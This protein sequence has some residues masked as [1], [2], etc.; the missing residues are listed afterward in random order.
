M[1]STHL[2]QC[3]YLSSLTYSLYFNT[4]LSSKAIIKRKKARKRLR[5]SKIITCQRKRSR[6]C[7]KSSITR[8]RTLNVT[9]YRIRGVGGDTEIT[10]LISILGI[11]L[12][13]S[14]TKMQNLSRKRSS[15]V[16]LRRVLLNTFSTVFQN[17]FQPFFTWSSTSSTYCASLSRF[18]NGADR[19]STVKIESIKLRIDDR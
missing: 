12:P 1:V 2:H 17:V 7:R 16:V 3:S 14:S 11:R 19:V 4:K 15:T 9:N 10:F 8:R 6:K 13:R 5:G 18:A